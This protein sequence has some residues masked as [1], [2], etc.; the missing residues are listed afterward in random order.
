VQTFNTKFCETVLSS[1]RDETHGLI[2]PTLYALCARTHRK[3]ITRQY[4]G[5]YSKTKCI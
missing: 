3:C 2:W 1:F 4:Y 5:L